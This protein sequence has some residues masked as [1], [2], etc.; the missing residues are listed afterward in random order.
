MRV[1]KSRIARSILSDDLAAVVPSPIFD[2]R[3][4]GRSYAIWPKYRPMSD[5]KIIRAVQKTRLYANLFAWLRGVAEVSINRNLSAAVVHQRCRLPLEHVRDNRTQSDEL[6]S[7]A[8]RALR[9]LEMGKWQPVS[10][11]QHTD[12]WLGN[13]LLPRFSQ[14]PLGNNFGFFAVDWG[15]S[16]VDGAPGF[17][18]VRLC[19]SSN[20]SLRRARREFANYMQSI[21]IEPEALISEVLVALGLIGTN[22]EELPE[23]RYLA[24]CASCLDYLRAVGFE[25]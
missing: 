14:Q 9:L 5:R 7:S 22:L 23:Y 13:I 17:D 21:K 24:M 18:L 16:V 15:G 20:I 1:Q 10:I 4:M 11:L 25:T 3:F 19:L 12:F 8:D 2:G 6:R